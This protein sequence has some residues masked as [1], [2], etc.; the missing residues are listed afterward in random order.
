[1]KAGIYQVLIVGDL[2]YLKQWVCKPRIFPVPSADFRSDRQMLMCF[3]SQP[4]PAGENLCDCRE[5][6]DHSAVILQHPMER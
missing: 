4:H 6:I 3:Q 1:M 5:R 2:G